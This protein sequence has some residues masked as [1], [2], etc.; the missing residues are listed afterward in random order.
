MLDA[1][2]DAGHALLGIPHVG[3]YLALAWIAY[4]V[5][6]GGWIVLQKRAPVAT[7]SW[8]LGLAALP[9]LGFVVYYVFGPQRIQRQRLR[10]ARHRVALPAG[11][12]R[13]GTGEGAELARVGHA[14]TGLPRSSAR[15]VTLL[16][17]GAAT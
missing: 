6:L 13:A 15:E 17:D 1:L 3:L 7:L 4:L 10:R 11:D 16:V 8:L 9:I 14:T 5:W 2:N 12:E